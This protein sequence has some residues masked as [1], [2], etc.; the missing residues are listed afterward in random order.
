MNSF[1]LFKAKFIRKMLRYCLLSFQAS[2]WRISKEQFSLFKYN[3]Q[4]LEN[5]H[6]YLKV[7]QQ[8][9]KHFISWSVNTVLTVADKMTSVFWTSENMQSC[10]DHIKSTIRGTFQ[11]GEVLSSIT[12]SLFEIF[13]PNLVNLYC[14]RHFFKLC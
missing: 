4:C 9:H 2:N 8:V 1:S 3:S 6:W 14:L 7:L 11:V 10:S 5:Y 13:Q 12:L